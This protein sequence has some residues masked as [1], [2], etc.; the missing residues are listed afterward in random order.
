MPVCSSCPEGTFQNGTGKVDCNPCGSDN[1][2]SNASESTAC[3]TCPSGSFTSGGNSS[4]K[5]ASC[6]A[7][8]TGSSCDGKSLVTVCPKGWF[9]D[10]PGQ[11][12]CKMCGMDHKYS[13]SDNAE[14][15]MV[16]PNSSYTSGGDYQTRILCL[17]CEDS[18][19][20]CNGSSY[21]I[22]E[23]M[24]AMAAARQ[25]AE[26]ETVG[27]VVGVIG[28]IIGVILVAVIVSLVVKSK[29]K[30]ERVSIAPA[31]DNN[32]I[33]GHTPNT[34]ELELKGM[35][36]EFDDTIDIAKSGAV[37]VPM[38]AID[39]SVTATV[40]LFG[41]RQP[42]TRTRRRKR[43]DRDSSVVDS[44]ADASESQRSQSRKSRRSRRSRSVRESQDVENGNL[45]DVSSSVITSPAATVRL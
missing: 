19:A 36:G 34:S 18:W 39:P 11:S 43:R 2:F 41:H 30:A 17:P 6:S 37:I 9:Q 22:R 16:C 3:K 26:E 28:A 31:P 15:C 40:D 38:S 14:S 35:D 33:H 1:M 21:V 44:S 27:T 7:C 5:R 24:A 29:M 25:A 45:E 32:I 20:F 42:R 10:E 4:L 8:P 13:P 23:D 12:E